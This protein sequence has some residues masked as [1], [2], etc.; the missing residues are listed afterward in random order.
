MLQKVQVEILDLIC[1]LYYSASHLNMHTGWVG[2][3]K[4]GQLTLTWIELYVPFQAYCSPILTSLWSPWQ[5][6]DIKTMSSAYDMHP[7]NSLPMWAPEPE[8]LSSE[9]RSLTYTEKRYGESTPLCRTPHS[10]GNH[11]PKKPFHLTAQCK[12]PYQL[13]SNNTKHSGA[14]LSSNFFV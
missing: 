7:I 6:G 1:P 3:A 4:R 10:I 8:Y 13:I 5:D 12:W 14:F 2:S 9:I 11:S